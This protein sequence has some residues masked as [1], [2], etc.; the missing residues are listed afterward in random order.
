MS[1]HDLLIIGAG[2]GNTIIGPEH[3]HLDIAIAEPAEFGGTCMNR[4]C[5]PSKML[6]YAADLSLNAQTANKLGVNSSFSGVDWEGIQRR[7]F[8]R[9]DPIAE[10]GLNYRESLENVTVYRDKAAF[11]SENTVALGKEVVSADQIVIAAGASPVIPHLSGLNETPFH[12]SDSIMRITSLPDHIVIVGGGFIAIEMAHIFGSFG[13][14]VTMILRGDELLR[15]ADSSIRERITRI[16][17]DRFTIYPSE[18]IEQ[19]SHAGKFLI[20]LK[21][22][23]AIEADELLIATGRYPNTGFLEPEKGGIE[24][25]EAGYV[26]TDEYLRTSAPR[27][28]ALG[29]VTNPLQ[30]KH[31]ANAEARIISHNLLNPENLLK[32]DRSVIPKAVFGN[33]QIATVGFTEDDLLNG[34]VPYLKSIR[35]Y[36]DT[37]FGW[38]MEDEQGFVKLLIDPSTRLLLGAHIIGYQASTLIQQLVTTMSISMTVDE[39]ARN[40]LYVHPALTE[41]IE[42]ALLGF[43]EE[44]E[45]EKI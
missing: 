32:I 40:Q 7:I 39:L 27:V 33:P 44:K 29:D 14:E 13:S 26:I 42:Q 35:D 25:D 18:E 12:T 3:D 43:E 9:I 4:G 8:G 16:Y 37:A 1:H 5:I 34:G 21:K 15:E 2:S 20:N 36:S 6:V 23:N 11:I 41:V 28:W 38:A 10:A 31:T 19:V 22:E 17:K 45:Q 30:L 24:C